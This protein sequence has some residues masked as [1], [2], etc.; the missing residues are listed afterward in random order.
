M[1]NIFDKIFNVDK[2]RLKEIEDKIN[3]VLALSETYRNMSD[4]ELKAKTVEFKEKLQ[5]GSS[6]DDI[7]VEA[8]ATI[9]EA[10]YRVI[11]EYIKNN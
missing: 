9:R 4:D 7:L 2:K 3:P 6:L 11:G 10:A 8:F 1:A 5:N